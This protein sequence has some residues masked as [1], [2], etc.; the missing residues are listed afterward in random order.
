MQVLRDVVTWLKQWFALAGTE[1]RSLS[2]VVSD[3]TGLINNKASQT[4]L[5]T[6]TSIVNTKVDKVTGKGLSTNDYTT[7]EKNK[8]AGIE[9]GANRTIVDDE[10]SISSTNP[11]Q[12]KVILEEFGNTAT[13]DDIT[14]LEGVIDD[15][16][17]E[18]IGSSYTNMIYNSYGVTVNDLKDFSLFVLNQ[19]SAFRNIKFIEIV[20]DKGTASADKLGK[21]FIVNENSKVN[22][23]YVKQTGTGA[24]ATYSWEKMDTNILDEYIV[25]W[26]DVQNKPP[27]FTPESHAHGNI[28]NDGTFNSVLAGYTSSSN[29]QEILAIN[30]QNS[31]IV[32]CNLDTVISRMNVP[33]KSHSSSATTY[34]VGTTANYGHNKVINDLTHNSFTNGESLSAYQGYVLNQTKQDKGDCVTSIELVPK[35]NDPL[36]DAYN[37]VIKLYYGDE[38]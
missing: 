33:P 27:V 25:Y 26:N 31:K 7:N 12:N 16:M 37:G 38:P 9:T 4:D 20:A 18:D 28:N 1:T 21:L 14:R 30:S 23:W 6:L 17:D 2:E 11:V 19:I 8:L 22:V 35:G 3:L 34:G 29:I 10:L 5:N 36:A 24:S 13:S 32:S 15:L